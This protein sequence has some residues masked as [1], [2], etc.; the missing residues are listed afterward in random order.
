MLLSVNNNKK[1]YQHIG[2][3][4]EGRDVTRERKWRLEKKVFPAMQT[5]VNE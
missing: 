4:Q 5:Y 1:A 3:C 2:S